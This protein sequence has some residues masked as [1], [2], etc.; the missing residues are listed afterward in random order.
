[1]PLYVRYAPTRVG[2][3]LAD[4]L[5]RTPDL[6]NNVEFVRTPN[7]RLQGKAIDV[8]P[9]RQSA[10]TMV[11]S[12][13]GSSVDITFTDEI[14]GPFPNNPEAA[15][16]GENRIIIASTSNTLPVAFFPQ[17]GTPYNANTV[18]G[19]GGASSTNSD[20]FVVF[21][22]SGTTTTITGLNPGVQYYF[23]TFEY[24]NDQVG[25]AENYRTPNLPITVLPPTPLP[26]ELVSFTAQ[27]RENK[28][29]LNWL[30]ASEKNNRGF[31]VQRSQNGQQFSVVL[32]REGR[33]TTSTRT[34]YDAVDAQP[35]PGLS[36]YR[37][38]QIDNDGTFAY[39]PVVLVQ[40]AGLTEAAFFP[41]PTTGKLTIQLPQAQAGNALRVRI[42]DLTGRLVREE[43]LPANGEVDMS[44]LQAGSYMITVGA[45]S[46]QVT[47]R[48]VKQ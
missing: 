42:L 12:A 7:G 23:F 45:D 31:E 41:N 8:E 5:F 24:N 48:I 46:Q 21:A 28:V 2:S 6:N 1:V 20:N 14:G 44:A 29:Q 40:N 26:V 11:R 18:Y 9:T 43:T 32:F 27:L 17:D 39:S 13:N 30:T 3:A 34:P 33:G 35:L 22:S 4:L 10:A 47:R 16:F 15:G 25:G 36:Y 38:K 19:A 37:L